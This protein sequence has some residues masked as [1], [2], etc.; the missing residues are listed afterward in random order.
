MRACSPRDRRPLPL[1][2]ASVTP[3][4]AL[5]RA[6]RRACSNDQR[7]A[8]PSAVALSKDAAASGTRTDSCTLWWSESKAAPS[9]CAAL[10]CLRNASVSST[11]PLTVTVAPTVGSVGPQPPRATHVPPH[12]SNIALSALPSAV[13]GPRCSHPSSASPQ[14]SRGTQAPF[15]R[16]YHISVGPRALQGSRASKQPAR[17][18]QRPSQ[19]SQPPRGAR[20]SH[21]SVATLQLRGMQLPPSMLR[22][23]IASHGS[24]AAAAVALALQPR[25]GSGCLPGAYLAA[26]SADAG[27]VAAPMW[28]TAHSS[29]RTAMAGGR[30]GAGSK[31]G[32]RARAPSAGSERG[33]RLRLRLRLPLPLPLRRS[34]SGSGSGAPAHRPPQQTLHGGTR[35]PFMDAGNW[36]APPQSS[37]GAGP[38]ILRCSRSSGSG[39]K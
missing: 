4:T 28:C 15:S 20:W 25:R 2:A 9:P 7:T 18:T 13:A 11:G 1:S 33:L 8:R 23:P 39:P 26:H 37:C 36:P 3:S 38:R 14:S 12:A 31:R 5:S 10:S 30:S 22:R 35:R 32:L 16:E 34:G 24:A 29:A 27:T 19:S 17:G 21:A 6:W